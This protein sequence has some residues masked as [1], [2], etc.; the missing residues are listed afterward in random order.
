[1]DDRIRQ[2]FEHHYP[3]LMLGQGEGHSF[4]R[5]GFD[6]GPGWLPLVF[7]LFG[8]YDGLQH[9]SDRAF[10]VTEVKEKYGSL[11][12]SASLP[13]FSLE[14]D[15]LESVAE[16]LS[17]QICDVCG[18]SASLQEAHGFYATRCPEHQGVSREVIRK[19]SQEALERFLGYER[20][21]LDTSGVA[22]AE[23]R[24]STSEG[25]GCLDVFALPERILSARHGLI[26]Q[27]SVQSFQDMPIE[28]LA[29]VLES[30]KALGKTVLG[31][32]DGSETGDRIFGQTSLV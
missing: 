30:L 28:H 26:E 16:H 9:Q 13:G 7:E 5:F 8:L 31:C 12:V 24:K 15:I 19:A 29:F 18:S 4:G 22:Y 23:A 2:K 25:L 1:M 20:Q 6:V 21:G 14:E 3:L 10:R 27:L 32:T 17:M 11:R